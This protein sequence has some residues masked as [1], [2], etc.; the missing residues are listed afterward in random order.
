[1]TH[2]PKI[3]PAITVASLEY[4]DFTSSYMEK[5]TIDLVR[6]FAIRRAV[7]NTSLDPK[8]VAA[9]PAV[10]EECGGERFVKDI[11]KV[12]PIDSRSK[13]P[14]T[15]PFLPYAFQ[16]ELPALRGTHPEVVLSSIENYSRSYSP[17]T[18]KMEVFD[19][20][21]CL[22]VWRGLVAGTVSSKV[23][24]EDEV[25]NQQCP[26]IAHVCRELGSE[27]QPKGSDLT[28]YNRSSLFHNMM[29]N[30][31]NGYR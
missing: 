2:T 28:D 18:Q 16:P 20:S 27:V 19:A 26:T 3:N 23:V 29:R 30:R 7:R 25:F 6:C 4:G 17:V 24:I 31:G 9:S 5:Y 22:A 8:F 1:M 13:W 15:Y 10:M 12:S 21:D 14:A 11:I